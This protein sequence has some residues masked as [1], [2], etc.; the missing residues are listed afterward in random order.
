MKCERN[1]TKED[2]TRKK[3][4]IHKRIKF[5]RFSGIDECILVTLSE[6]RIRFD[7]YHPPQ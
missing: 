1:R 3:K 5:H 4:T 7:R 6:G 2:C